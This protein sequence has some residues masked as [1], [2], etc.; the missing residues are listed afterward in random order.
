MR[1]LQ[2]LGLIVVQQRLPEMSVNHA[3]VER[4]ADERRNVERLADERRFVGQVPRTGFALPPAI[5]IA[6]SIQRKCSAT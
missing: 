3:N 1:L 6:I 2:L 4:L 5:A